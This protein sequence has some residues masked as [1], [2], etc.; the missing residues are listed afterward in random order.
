MRITAA[1]L[2]ALML[3]GC[4]GNGVGT[5]G[6]SSGS[7]TGS[8]TIGGEVTTEDRLPVSDTPYQITVDFS[9]RVYDRTPYLKKFDQFA[10][11][12]SWCNDF[13]AAPSLD[14]KNIGRVP[15]VAEL[16]PGSIR[17]DLFMGHYGIGREIGNGPGRDGT[18]DEEYVLVK[19]VTDALKASGLAAEFVYFASPVNVGGGAAN[20]AWKSVKDLEGWEE[21]CR[22][23]AACFDSNE[24]NVRYHEVWNE[25]D[26]YVSDPRKD[27]VYFIG[28]WQDYIDLYLHGA[29]G[30][31]AGD[32]DAMVGGVSAAWMNKISR[33]GEL[34]SFLR[35]AREADLLPDYLSWHFYGSN[36]G[37]KMLEE[38]ISGARSC[39]NADDD[40][41]TVQQHLNE[42]NVSLDPE[43]TN[44][45]RMVRQVL[46]VYQRLLRAT[47][48]TRVVWTSAL[49]RQ[50]EGSD[51]QALI[52][53]F[54]G[55]RTPAYYT[56]WMYA[57]LPISPVLVDSDTERVAVM[58]SV[59]DGRAALIAYDNFFEETEVTFSL[60]G[61][62]AERYH[63]RVLTIDSR[64]PQNKVSSNTPQLLAEYHNVAADDSLAYSVRIPRDGAIYVELT[65]TDGV[66]PPHERRSVLAD[67]V[68]RTD[69]WYDGRCDDGAYAWI[70]TGSFVGVLGSGTSEASVGTACAVT[71]D[72]MKGEELTVDA[73]V[74][75]GLSK[76]SD[77]SMCGLIVSYSTEDGY[78]GS[79]Y[80]ALNGI[81]GG[82]AIPLGTGRVCD[83]VRSLGEGSGERLIALDDGA[84]ENWNGRIML[85]L[86][87]NDIPP[88]E[89]AE[90]ILGLNRS[91]ESAGFKARP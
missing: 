75:E 27:G 9:E 8:A 34:Q 57:R 12:W 6:D 2:L 3:G 82:I 59:E 23:I 55:E 87:V 15:D 29:R 44:S 68:V 41:A 33:N 72:G 42:F 61:L 14:M 32:P 64:N 78:T 35:Q 30:I 46:N 76:R 16:L 60:K 84:P 17:T 53:P 11:T 80:H 71:L 67:R 39:L 56:Q 74:S 43:V 40:Y 85:T 79:I 70:S 51:A 45:Y 48:I 1:G 58:A 38:Y 73:T 31:R 91:D 10:A 90:L 13:T 5:G 21:L 63:V 77:R 69:G 49:D 7:G 86:V 83:E 54:T 18:T 22:N 37:M 36:G 19:G 66:E 88:G 50:L 4:A 81:D 28:S 89:G 52:N 65:P 26:Y 20:D 47:D 62:P 25:P 24:M